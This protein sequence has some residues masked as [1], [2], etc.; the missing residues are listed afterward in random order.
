MKKVLFSVMFF[1]SCLAYGQT[2]QMTDPLQTVIS[3][4]NE[5]YLNCN[6]M[7]K[8]DSAL[9]QDV[10]EYLSSLDQEEISKDPDK[11]AAGVLN[12][13]LGGFG[14]GHFYTGQTIRG[15]LDVLFC[16]TGIPAAIGLV[17][18][19]IWLCE[20]DDAWNE[21]VAKWNAQK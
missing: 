11:V 21:R 4:E 14:V 8:E 15:V 6:E 12:I 16:W 10:V 19:I 20:D 7:T 18:G 13:L 3:I 2:Q 5:N 9:V 17:E 1:F